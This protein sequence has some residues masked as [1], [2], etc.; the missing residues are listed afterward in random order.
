MHPRLSEQPRSRLLLWS[1]SVHRIALGTAR[2]NVSG[3]RAMPHEFAYALT[4]AMQGGRM[5]DLR[6]WLCLHFSLR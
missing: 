4:G 3:L 1:T 2:R 5:V 6:A